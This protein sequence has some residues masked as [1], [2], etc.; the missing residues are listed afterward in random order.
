[1]RRIQRLSEV[2]CRHHHWSLFLRGVSCGRSLLSRCFKFKRKAGGWGFSGSVTMVS[3]Y[4]GGKKGRWWQRVLCKEDNIKSERKG[5]STVDKASTFR[6]Y[7]LILECLLFT[8]CTLFR[9]FGLI[10]F[11]SFCTS[12]A[13]KVFL[14][15]FLYLSIIS[16]WTSVSFNVISYTDMHGFMHR[17]CRRTPLWVCTKAEYP[18]PE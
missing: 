8:W 16:W 18:V 12:F 17:A 5:G 11:I 14:L 15:L 9:M 6:I 13:V 2:A 7:V 1:M 10:L 3:W 4:D